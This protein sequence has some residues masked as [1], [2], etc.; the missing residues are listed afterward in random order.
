[1]RT[2]KKAREVTQLGESIFGNILTGY[3]LTMLAFLAKMPQLFLE[4]NSRLLS[5][6]V[7]APYVIFI[8]LPM[9]IAASAN[10]KV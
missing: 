9:F 3:Y 10:T 1:M 8:L 7:M 5:R 2:Y 6:I 4:P